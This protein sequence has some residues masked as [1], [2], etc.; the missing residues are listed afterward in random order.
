M[1]YKTRSV[2]TAIAE[3]DFTKA[4]SLRDP[5]FAEMLDGFYATSLLLKEPKLPHHLVRLPDGIA[6]TVD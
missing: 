5:E 1:H 4:R 3:K 2:A 6:R